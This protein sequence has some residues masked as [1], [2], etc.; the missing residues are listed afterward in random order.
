M[1]SFLLL[2]KA[3]LTGQTFFEVRMNGTCPW[4]HGNLTRNE[5]ARWERSSVLSAFQQKSS[6]TL[7]SALLPCAAQLLHSPVVLW[8]R[9]KL[10]KTNVWVISISPSPT[11]F[12][13]LVSYLWAVVL[14]L[15]KR[16]VC[17]KSRAGEKAVFHGYFSLIPKLGNSLCFMSVVSELHNINKTETR[18]AAWNCHWQLLMSFPLHVLFVAQ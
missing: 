18:N 14:L 12:E 7:L 1:T 17:A 10:V 9:V 11:L 2:D 4:R 16:C 3:V 15:G 8:G 5:G 13:K 6:L